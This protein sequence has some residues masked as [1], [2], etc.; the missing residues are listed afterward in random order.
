M[1]AAK[2]VPPYT[3]HPAMWG[4]KLILRILGLI[5]GITALA[6]AGSMATPGI[7][8][9]IPIMIVA[10]PGCLS[11]AW[12]VAEGIC[13]LARGGHRGIHPGA[14]VGLDLIIWLGLAGADIGLWLIGIASWVVESTAGSYGY[15]SYIGY[16]GS[17]SSYGYNY[18]SN[19]RSNLLG[20]SD[21]TNA[22]DG[23]RS[24]G[25]ALMGITAVLTIIHFSTFVIACYETHIRRRLRRGPIV[26]M[27]TTTPPAAPQPVYY[28]PQQQQQQ[29]QSFLLQPQPAHMQQMYSPG[30]PQQHPAYDMPKQVEAYQVQQP[31]ASPPPPTYQAPHQ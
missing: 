10:G 26:V 16:G 28:M 27:Q 31:A 22:V 13:I 2:P 1:E 15:G 3:S 23:V 18:G 30:Q 8:S 19:Y 12:N 6:L 11:I 29:Q 4:S 20:G 17:S 21:L 5:F 9:S 25:S 24:K 7:I 14:N